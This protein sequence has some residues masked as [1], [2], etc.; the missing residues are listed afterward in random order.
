LFRLCVHNVRKSRIP[1]LFTCQIY[2]SK[3]TKIWAFF[4]PGHAGVTGNERADRL[5]GKE[6]RKSGRIIDRSEILHAIKEA[7]RENNSLKDIESV[8]MTRLYEHRVG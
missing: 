3:L 1:E 8:S 6:K 5:A 2:V 4:V 7:S